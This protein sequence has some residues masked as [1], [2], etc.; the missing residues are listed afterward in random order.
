V[1][2]IVFEAM[3]R[4]GW[5][6][7]LSMAEFLR[8]PDVPFIRWQ[9]KALVVSAAL[10]VL[11]IVIFVGKPGDRLGIEF[12]AGTRVDVNVRA[13]VTADDIRSL[14]RAIRK[15]LRRGLHNMGTS[16]GSGK[17]NFY[18]VARRPARN[19][20]DLKVFRRT[21]QPCPRCK[22]AIDRIIVGQRS[23]HLCPACQPPAHTK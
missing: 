16:L 13:G 5:L 3:I 17:A 2:R 22:T 10:V 4:A 1:T 18:S 6:R 8:D 7:T 21:G 14:H 11:A 23:T 15:V 20:D 19:Q 9:R 12:S